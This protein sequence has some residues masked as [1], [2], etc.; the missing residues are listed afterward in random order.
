MLRMEGRDVF[1]IGSMTW[2]AENQ[3]NEREALEARKLISA[4]G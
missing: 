4:H 1:Y 3:I 2:H